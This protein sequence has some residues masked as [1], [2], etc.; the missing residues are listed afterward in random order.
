V[1]GEVCQLGCVREFAEP[2][3]VGCFFE[4]RALG[5]LV[6]VDTAVG[7]NAG[8]AVDKAD[9]RAGGDDALGLSVRQR[10]T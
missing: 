1:F 4:G 8:V 2:E 10:W 5:K 6:D 9:G 7:E 3:E